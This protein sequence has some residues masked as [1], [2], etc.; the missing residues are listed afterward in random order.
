MLMVSVV[1]AIVPGVA[2]GCV[3]KVPPTFAGGVTTSGVTGVVERV[4]V[5]SNPL[6]WGR[7]VS[8]VTRI[9]GGVRTDRWETS[10]ESTRRC[11]APDRIAVGSRTFEFKGD[12]D[13]WTHA[14]ALTRSEDLSAEETLIV[15]TTFGVPQEFAVSSVDRAMATVRVWGLESGLGLLVLVV[16][17][18]AW[19]RRRRERRLDRHL[20]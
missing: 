13:A 11:V 17:A 4:T 10:G 7:S 14:R 8:V 3:D 5:A 15:E 9:W 1:L 18:G 6:P 19:R 2:E 12:A 16:V 20:F